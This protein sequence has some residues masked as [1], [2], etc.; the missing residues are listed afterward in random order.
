MRVLTALPTGLGS[1]SA[2]HVAPT[3]PLPNIHSYKEREES[4]A[5]LDNESAI[6]S[7]ENAFSD[8]NARLVDAR[9][10]CACLRKSLASAK[11][12]AEASDASK[13]VLERELDSAHIALKT[14][15]RALEE[16]QVSGVR[17]SVPCPIL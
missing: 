15:N 3:D 5:V 12:L 4:A 13:L 10:D 14:C 7:H 1:D 9:E 16:K 8:I 6:V 11:A 17:F 2:L